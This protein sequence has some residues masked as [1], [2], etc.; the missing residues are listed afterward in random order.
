MNKP[1]FEHDGYK[2]DHA[3]QYHS[4]TEEI[5][6]SYINRNN[7]YGQYSD[8]VVFF[9][10]QYYIKEWLI[11]S[12][13][14]NFF[15][16]PKQ[17][18]IS[19]YK[20]LLDNYL[21][22]DFDVSR[23]SALHDLGYLPLKIKALQEGSFVNLG[24]PVLTIK[25]TK[26]EFFWLT[27]FIETSLSAYLWKP[28]TNATLSNAY[29]TILKRY[30][31]LTCDNDFHL[32]FQ[33]HDFSMRGMSGVKDAC[34]SGASHL[35]SFK[36]TDTIP[37][38][39]LIEKYYNGDIKNIGFSIPATEHSVSTTNILYNNKNNLGNNLLESE[40]FFI[41]HLITEVY[42]KGFV[43][44]VS[45]SFDYWG[46]LTSLKNSSLKDIILNREGKVVIRPDS[47]DPVEVIC[48]KENNPLLKS[49]PETAISENKGSM[50]VLWEA[51]GGTIN[52]KGFKVLNEKIGL[53]FGD[54]IT[55]ERAE[56]ICKKLEKAGFASSNI[57]FGVGSYSMNYNTRD[58]FSGA[59]KATSCLIDGQRFD[60]YKSPKT[61]SSKKSPKGLLRVEKLEKDYILF[62]EQTEEQEEL[63][64][65]ETVFENGILVK[66]ISF[67]EIR[68]NLKN[69]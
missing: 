27:N 6:S 31:D 13:N 51:F 69:S 62:D 49:D 12:W 54:S 61:D 56:T 5:Y 33:A 44:I 36:G 50:Q 46:L 57:V 59:I 23:L 43:S 40:E 11:D 45:D 19:E 26:K 28:M 58:T 2:A 30:S 34:L 42:P 47:G 25:N 3:S 20:E 37:A 29:K 48:G 64:L 55:L 41:K 68:N 53:I 35:I 21:Q 52:S 1:F 9:G 66:D 8:K 67:E 4:K 38:I 63:G 60:I 24:V 18:V 15:N 10:L 32:D 16:K 7:K 17:E 14:E 39:K 22:T 65:L